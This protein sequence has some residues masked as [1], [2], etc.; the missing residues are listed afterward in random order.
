MDSGKD[1]GIVRSIGHQ[2]SRVRQDLQTARSCYA[3]RKDRLVVQ[4]RAAW[5][6][7][8]WRAEAAPGFLGQDAI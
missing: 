8:W 6:E 5:L 4:S 3:L 2:L 7:S 1:Y